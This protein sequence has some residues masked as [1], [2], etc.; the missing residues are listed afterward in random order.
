MKTTSFK[1]S[2]KLAEI[3]FLDHTGSFW[4]MNPDGSQA[5]IFRCGHGEDDYSV[6]YLPSY[7]LET[8]LEALPTEIEDKNTGRFFIRYLFGN[9]GLDYYYR[10]DNGDLVCLERVYRNSNECLAD[11]SARLLILLHEKKLIQF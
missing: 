11:T 4:K 3:G 8:I 1:I 2:K 9:N 6:E 5:S 10:N 7:D